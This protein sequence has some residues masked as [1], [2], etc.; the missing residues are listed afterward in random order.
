V[1]TFYHPRFL[2]SSKSSSSSL[3]MAAPKKETDISRKNGQSTPSSSRKR[4]RLNTPTSQHNTPA[5]TN[6]KETANGHPHSETN[7]NSK[8]QS[9]STAAQKV[10]NGVKG[11]QNPFL[12]TLTAAHLFE[13]S[14][15][16][17]QPGTEIYEEPPSSPL[18]S[19]PAS[20]VG[21]LEEYFRRPKAEPSP[22]KEATPTTAIDGEATANLD[23]SL[24]GLEIALEAS[25][26]HA[27]PSKSS[28]RESH[29]AS[30]ALATTILA[31]VET[32][33]DAPNG[34]TS[35]S[36]SSRKRSLSSADELSLPDPPIKAES[37]KVIARTRRKTKSNSP[38]SNLKD[39]LAPKL[40]EVASAAGEDTI[41][42]EE[43]VRRSKRTKTD[44][45]PDI[46]FDPDDMELPYQEASPSEIAEWDGWLE[47]ESS[48]VS[49]YY[50]CV[51]T[52]L[53]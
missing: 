19:P 31:K 23:S 7:G 8:D 27:T 45:L 5:P 37:S 21:D 1:S 53:M 3:K 50:T 24:T 51:M 26:G 16:H 20:M 39:D 4:S 30:P 13:L 28:S 11:P 46:E 2:I 29:Q 12:N 42:N 14:N 36:R 22:A 35:Q 15:G 18:S 33:I 34:D 44:R 41:S 48:P 32:S 49:L 6:I 25:K 38:A 52:L 17:A 9:T 43:P 10:T 47:M 40:D